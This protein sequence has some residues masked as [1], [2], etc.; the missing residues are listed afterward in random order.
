MGRFGP[1]V[2]PSRLHKLGPSVDGAE[3]GSGMVTQKEPLFLVTLSL[4]IP[5]STLGSLPLESFYI[6]GPSS[7]TLGPGHK[8]DEVYFALQ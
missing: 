8:T 5:A 4:V 3:L 7:G 1:R 6:W 2:Q